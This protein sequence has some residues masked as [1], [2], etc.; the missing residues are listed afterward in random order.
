LCTRPVLSIGGVASGARPRA[1]ATLLGCLK[2][3]EETPY[4]APA[5]RKA[6]PVSQNPQRPN[7]HM[8]SGGWFTSAEC[9][10]WK[11]TRVVG[12]GG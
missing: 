8:S 12:K 11:E 4:D 10:D 1:E 5:A 9:G 6:A 7:M 2:G 3:I